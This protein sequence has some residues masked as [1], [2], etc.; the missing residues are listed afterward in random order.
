LPSTA[1]VRKG[2][3]DSGLVPALISVL[4]SPNEDLL[5]HSA[6]ALSRMCYDNSK[7]Q[8]QCVRCGA[9]PR[10]VSILFR[11]SE[12]P[13]L[14]EACLLALCNLSGLGLSEEGGVSWERGVAMRP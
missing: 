13:L 2:F 9:V 8:D 4:T 7:L 6:T 11:F 5:I 10:L 3:G 12:R 14:E 1:L